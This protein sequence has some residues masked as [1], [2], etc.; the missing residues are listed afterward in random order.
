MATEVP[1]GDNPVQFYADHFLSYKRRNKLALA[2]EA[3]NWG[4][5]SG[6]DYKQWD[7]RQ[8][9][10]LLEEARAPHQVNFI[11][12]QI[13]SLAGNFYQNGFE[14]DFEPNTGASS[15]D[16]LLLK[17]LY[18]TDVNTGEWEKAKRLLIRAGLI[19]RGTVEMFIDYKTDRRGTI[20]TRYVN[21]RRMLFD[22][23]WSSDDVADNK[24]IK[25]YAWMTPE[26]IKRVYKTQSKEVDEAITLY[27]QAQSNLTDDNISAQERQDA[28]TYFDNAEF[29]NIIDGR[30][31]VIQDSRLERGFSQSGGEKP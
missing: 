15:D 8:L 19:F 16:T 7:A 3:R 25:Q 4:F 27:R 14:S 29:R 26:E 12:K 6:V 23:D 9:Q 11:Q 10:V 18:L 1:K 24:H 28:L 21:H 17:T 31:L 13:Q 20:S 22:P 5:F 30:F 2:R